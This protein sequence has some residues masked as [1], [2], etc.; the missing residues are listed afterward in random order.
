[1]MAWKYTLP[2]FVVPFMFTIN[3]DGLGLLLQAPW[4]TVASVTVTA[5]FGLIALAA[6]ITGWFLRRATALERVLLAAAGIAL[7][8]PSGL[9][10]VLAIAAVLGIA[11]TQW[12][13]RPRAQELPA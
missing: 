2:A 5:V 9:H 7:I 8:Y 4:Q 12:L 11:A 6:A 10:D 1:M 3:K 13:R